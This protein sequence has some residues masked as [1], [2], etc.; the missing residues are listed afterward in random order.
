MIKKILNSFQ[1]IECTDALKIYRYKNDNANFKI[2]YTINRLNKK[3]RVLCQSKQILC[4]Y[5]Y[6]LVRSFAFELKPLLFPGDYIENDAICILIIKGSPSIIQGLDEGLYLS[7]NLAI[8]KESEKNGKIIVL[9][10]D[11]FLDYYQ[12]NIKN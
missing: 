11:Q 5:Y 6:S 9:T 2:A 4:K 12:N 8:N 10:E 1:Y 7:Y 3:T